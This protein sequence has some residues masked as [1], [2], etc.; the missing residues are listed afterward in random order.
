VT[1]KHSS[2]ISPVAAFSHPPVQVKISFAPRK[3]VLH[4]LEENRGNYQH[5]NNHS[6]QRDTALHGQTSQDLK[7]EWSKTARTNWLE[8]RI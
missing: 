1:T 5:L 4:L 2:S 3:W 7:S 6:M 8:R